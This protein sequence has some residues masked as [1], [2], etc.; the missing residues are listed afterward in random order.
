[1]ILTY[2]IYYSTKI[3]KKHRSYCIYKQYTNRNL[4]KF[5]LI[6]YVLWPLYCFK[7]KYNFYIKVQ[8]GYYF[9]ESKNL[10]YRYNF[11]VYHFTFM[12]LC[13]YT[14]VWCNVNMFVVYYISA[15]SMSFNWA[16][17]KFIITLGQKLH[18]YD[19]IM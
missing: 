17:K 14:Y 2:T 1:M 19:K 7:C 3:N 6:T 9:H 13:C 16:L 8:I 15:P 4:K 10:I 11:L 18:D 12:L 5:G